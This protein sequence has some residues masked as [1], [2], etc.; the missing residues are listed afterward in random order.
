MRRLLIVLVLV[1]VGVVVLG[2][3][4]E[5]LKVTTSSDTKTINVNLVVDKE[6]IHEDQEKAKEKVRQMSGQIRDKAGS[7]TDKKDGEDKS[8][9]DPP[10]SSE[11]QKTNRIRGNVP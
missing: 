6:K 9:G 8:P 4:R 7:P 11:G 2:Y 5:W 3:F 10:H 1:M